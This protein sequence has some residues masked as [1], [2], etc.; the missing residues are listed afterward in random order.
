MLFI[1]S[2]KK[3]PQIA[4][5]ANHHDAAQGEGFPP[6]PI[7]HDDDEPGNHHEDR[8]AQRDRP[9]EIPA[10]SKGSLRIQEGPLEEHHPQVQ[11]APEE[12]ERNRQHECGDRGKWRRLRRSPSHSFG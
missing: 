7:R 6:D 11:V 2:R 12:A 3:A 10:T 9:G 5:V 4:S 8:V 1:G